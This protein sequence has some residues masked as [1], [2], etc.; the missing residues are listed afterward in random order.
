MVRSLLS[1]PVVDADRLLALLIS[2]LLN[3]PSILKVY[4]QSV[5]IAWLK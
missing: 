4:S 3:P 2:H 1:K 5:M